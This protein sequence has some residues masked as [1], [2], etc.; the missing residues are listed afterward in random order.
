MAEELAR[1]RALPL[2]KLLKLLRAERRKG[3]NGHWAYDLP[4]HRAMLEV[5]WERTQ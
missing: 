4:R 3:I 2:A 1:W 5:Y